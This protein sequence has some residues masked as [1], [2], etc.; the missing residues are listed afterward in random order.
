MSTFEIEKHLNSNCQ[1]NASNNKWNKGLIFV[2]LSGGS[3]L[4]LSIIAAPFVAP[5]FR[6][7]S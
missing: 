2:G 7:V 1:K 5:A 3:A 6:K 4:V